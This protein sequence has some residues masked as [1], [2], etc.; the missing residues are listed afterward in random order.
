MPLQCL[1]KPSYNVCSIKNI[2]SNF[3]LPLTHCVFIM[4][5]ISNSYFR[6]QIH[7]AKSFKMRHITYL[8]FTYL[9]RYSLIQIQVDMNFHK[10]TH[11]IEAIDTFQTMIRKKTFK[12]AT[13]DVLCINF[14]FGILCQNW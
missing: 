11:V 14:G 13:C 1:V 7:N 4:N 8:Y 3:Y 2:C 10:M 5:F 6:L 12:R 9:S